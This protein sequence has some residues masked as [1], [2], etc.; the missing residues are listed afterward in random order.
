MSIHSLIMVGS[1]DAT[2]DLMEG[3]GCGIAVAWLELDG[4]DDLTLEAAV[5]Q[6][7]A[8]GQLH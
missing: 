2:G 5:L 4:A 8:L 3:E 7:D 1:V 6:A